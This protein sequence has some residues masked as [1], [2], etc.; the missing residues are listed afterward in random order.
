VT[1]AL[2]AVAVPAW[3]AMRLQPAAVLRNE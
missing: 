1:V 2:L 3:R